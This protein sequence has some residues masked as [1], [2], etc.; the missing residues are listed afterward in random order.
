M[1]NKELISFYEDL[2]CP[3]CLGNISVIKETPKC[4]LCRIEYQIKEG[5]PDLRKDRSSYYCEFPK[6]EIEQ[7]LADAKKDLEG[8]V[9]SYLKNKQ[10]PPK[11][12]EYIMGSGRAGWKYLLPISANSRILD[13][14]CGWGTLA[15]GLAH[16]KCEVVALDSTL[17]RMRLLFTRSVQD[18]LKNLRTVCAG[19]G[20]HLPFSDDTF[21]IVIVNGVLEWIP[22][23][24]PG[25]PGKL[26]R[27]F[28]KEIR[29][30]LTPSGALL[31]GIENRY[32]WK[33]WFRNP[34][35][36]TGLRF[37]PWL[38]RFLANM[39]SKIKGHGQY[40]NW[41]YGEKQYKRLLSHE[42]FDSSS[43]VVPLPGYQ[44]PVWMVPL[45]QPKKIAKRVRRSVPSPLMKTLQYV[46]GRLTAMFPDAFTIIASSE[47]AK[48][49]F[50]DRL[51]RHLNDLDISGWEDIPQEYADY[52]IN[53]EMGIVT[54]LLQKNGS[55]N[56]IKLPLHSRAIIE[57]EHEVTFFQ[58]SPKQLS[59]LLPRVISKGNFDAQEYFVYT[60]VPGSSGEGFRIEDWRLS[61]VLNSA[62]ELLV[63][64]DNEKDLT[65]ASSQLAD[66]EQKVLSLASSESQRNCVNNA[67]KRCQGFIEAI[68]DDDWI[69]GHGDFK[70]ANCIL[71]KDS[72]SIQGVIDWGGWSK[73]ELPG[74]DLAFLL[75]DIK[76]RFGSSLEESIRLWRDNLPAESWAIQAIEHFNLATNRNIG[77]KEW[78]AIMAWQWLKRLAP[79]ADLVECKRF[80][81]NYLNR[82]FDVYAD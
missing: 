12:G 68:S 18:G 74:Y 8:T 34:D 6:N 73:K 30:V 80:D 17:E 62:V 1:E 31:L 65:N 7:F 75:T 20:K 63:G 69:L 14:G 23:G 28:L 16:S 33:T 49:N 55:G 21:D 48:P 26:Q 25:D 4:K 40:R 3:E 11:L 35:G 52:R 39:Y 45:T 38:P 43:F 60:F 29:R 5:I 51:L 53:G 9:R 79:L 64:F 59:N 27:E 44:H 77:D 66:I 72:L 70:L 67:V 81:Y 13:L 61:K 56:V 32:A 50:L 2:R 82:M 22:S 78:K 46:K 19:D 10:L 15:Y 47:H 71:A 57:L 24:L 58:Q 36:H 42:G 54:I 37:V 41:L 76:W